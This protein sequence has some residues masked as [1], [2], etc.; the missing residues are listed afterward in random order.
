MAHM[1]IM[2]K[3]M[4]TTIRFRGYRSIMENGSY[5]SILALYGDSGKEIESYYS[6]TGYILGL[7]ERERLKTMSAFGARP[8]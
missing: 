3:K 2:D 1:G 8:P 4:E 6:I 5:Y 7:Q